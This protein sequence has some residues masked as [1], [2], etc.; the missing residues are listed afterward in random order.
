MESGCFESSGA[1]IDAPRFLEVQ[2]LTF[3][4]KR[5]LYREGVVFE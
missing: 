1:S 4:I 5:F 2:P 3:H